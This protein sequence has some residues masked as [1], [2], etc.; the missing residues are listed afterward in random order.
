MTDNTSKRVILVTGATGK[1]GSATIDALIANGALDTHTLVAVTRNPASGSAKKLA[2]RGVQ[3]VQGD[4]NDVPAIFANVK[5]QLSGGGNNTTKVWGVFSVQVAVGRG[6]SPESEERQGKALVDAALAHG[7][8]HFVYTSGD[9]GGE[10]RSF[11]SPTKIPHFVSKYNIE[12]HLVDQ[13]AAAAAASSSSNGPAMTW[14]ILRPVAFMENF[15]PGF[16]TKIMATGMRVSLNGKPLQFVSARDIGW[17]AAQAFLR[18]EAYAGRS[19]TLA[20]DELTLSDMRAVFRQKTG[21]DMPETFQF[22]AHIV[23]WLSAEFGSMFRWFH[24]EGFGADLAALRKEH[25]ELQSW[26]DWL[27]TESEWVAKSK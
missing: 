27:E 22:V 23:F 13:A 12:H 2:T 17:F 10:A 9:R 5:K 6:A 16:G 1:Q 4:L 21:R 26:G 8:A 19:V 18:P 7:V 14:T 24:D 11:S 25:P 15:T 3:L 20:G